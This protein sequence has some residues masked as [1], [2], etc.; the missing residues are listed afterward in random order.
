[1]SNTQSPNGGGI[2][3]PK[4]A[5]QSPKPNLVTLE[6]FEQMGGALAELTDLGTKRILEQGD[7]AKRRALTQ[8]LGDQFLAHADEFLGSWLVV[9]REYKPLIGTLT[10]LFDRI[11][12][13]RAFQQHTLAPRPQNESS[14][15][16]SGSSEPSTPSEASSPTPPSAP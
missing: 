7:A 9:N 11:G 12:G 3:L 8:F 14:P 13:F 15:S 1:M 10:A 2:L 4:E 5:T 6:L 16:T